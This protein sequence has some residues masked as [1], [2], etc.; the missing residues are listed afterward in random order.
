MTMLKVEHS[1]EAH[2]AAV[3][4]LLASVGQ[5]I[6]R[7]EPDSEF[8][9]DPIIFWIE[10]IG[11]H[12]IGDAMV[13]FDEMT[14][15]HLMS[16]HDGQISFRSFD[17]LGIKEV[18]YYGGEPATIA[19][20]AGKDGVHQFNVVWS[21]RDERNSVIFLPFREE[22]EL[23]FGDPFARA[24]YDP[25][26]ELGSLPHG[27]GSVP[28]SDFRAASDA[29]SVVRYDLVLHASARPVDPDPF[30]TR[31]MGLLNYQRLLELD[32]GVFG[33]ACNWWGERL[34][35]AVSK[36]MILDCA[37]KLE[38]YL[39]ALSQQDVEWGDS[40]IRYGD[41]KV[42]L[43]KVTTDVAGRQAA[44]F[45]DIGNMCEYHAALM[46]VDKDDVG[47]PVASFTLVPRGNGEFSE[48]PSGFDI[49][50]T[51]WPSAAVEPASGKVRFERG[52]L[53]A[54]GLSTILEHL[55]W[56][57]GQLHL[58]GKVGGPDVV[59]DFDELMR[60]DDGRSTKLSV[61]TV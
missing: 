17:L 40:F 52:F 3:K 19:S 9:R 44:F 1:T 36:R 49:D 54:D 28:M 5:T 59:Q 47:T 18:D 45:V 12:V 32:G 30:N 61:N 34:L 42:N 37:N 31:S 13:I 26:V 23:G 10:N 11:E 2:N 39:Q 48:L 60:L 29:L 50:N 15:P 57:V 56:T 46:W 16:D 58:T 14:R 53:E 22:L 41:D 33:P 35:T 38:T 20:V 27:R 7:S 24:E 8:Y 43:T 55:K 25:A 51:Q 4:S 6:A 21:R